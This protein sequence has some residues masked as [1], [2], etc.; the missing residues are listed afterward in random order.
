MKSNEMKKK[1]A[2]LEWHVV[3]TINSHMI[4][5]YMENFLEC[6]YQNSNSPQQKQFL[7][8]ISCVFEKY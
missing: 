7:F 5:K 6:H 4:E 1:Q 8:G 3:Y 2:P